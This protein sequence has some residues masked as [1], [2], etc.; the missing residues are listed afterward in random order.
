MTEERYL[1]AARKYRPQR[2][3]ELVAQEHVAET[4]RNAIRMDRL[5]HV[6]LFSGPRGVGK[7]TTA[8]ILAKAINCTGRGDDPEPCRKCNS[9]KD[10]ESQRSL[11]IFEIDAASNNKVD[12]VRDLRETVHIPPQG[13][14]RKIYIIDEV[15]MLS[16][17]AFNALLKTLEEPPSYALFIFA[18]TEPH[19]VLPTIL[20]RCQRFDFRR[21]P[22]PAILQHLKQI[23]TEEGITADEES[24][25]LIARKGDGALRDAL[26][27][28]DQ[29][30]ALCGTSLV[31][32]EL[33][34]ALRVVDVDYFFEIVEFIARHE[35]SAIL[36]F[37][38]R[39]LSQGFDIREFLGG[40]AEHLRKLLVAVTVGA[41]LLQDVS[42]AVRARY[43]SQ[44]TLLTQAQLLRMLM[45][46]DDAL[47]ALPMATS[48]RLKFELALLKMSSLSHG[49]DLT[50][51]LTRLRNLE[52][53][54]KKGGL[55]Q[56]PSGTAGLPPRPQPTPAA[57]RKAPP[58]GQ[59]SVGAGGAKQETA[60]GPEAARYPAPSTLHVPEK[61][62]PPHL[63][64]VEP[65]GAKQE[66]VSEPQA[67]R[68]PATPTL[69]VPEKPPPPSQPDVGPESAKPEPAREPQAARSPAT[70]TLRVPEKPPPP[71]QPDVGPGSAMP[72]PARDP[73]TPSAPA[74]M[75]K[76]AEDRVGS[77]QRTA[78]QVDK[79]A[80]TTS[81]PTEAA[82]VPVQMNPEEV[83][84]QVTRRVAESHP[85][86]A[87]T[88]K[89]AQGAIWRND[90]LHVR[91]AGKSHYELIEG[92]NIEITAAIRAITQ[93][94]GLTLSL[95][96]LPAKSKQQQADEHLDQL[97]QAS[98]TVQ[99]MMDLFDVEI[100]T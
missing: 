29:A 11:N 86:T 19:K 20:S 65:G 8:R 97:R 43:S 89:G 39:V 79:A 41:P 78:E 36:L 85:S 64:G 22:V 81:A 46:A 44:S 52:D 10:L 82:A 68:S 51:A 42:E 75:E 23:C 47:M 100:V 25:L 45:I 34:A 18:T 5:A 71:S 74:A 55:R 37:S 12:D 7:T 87:D 35:T 62:S 28:F 99:V 32:S 14:I 49:L 61:T 33:A 98:P 15:H 93:N 58:H 95:E 30:V 31:Y 77:E 17:A 73:T 72:E 50:E 3:G 63:G 56:M 27:A 6:Y 16:N 21:I 84:T 57:T 26:S 48:P 53:L 66:P 96:M 60:R 92:R 91:I 94:P 2:F 59:I 38:D 90:T 83:W 88:M 24:L 76:A 40:L 54:L 4:L 80:K 1:V 9:C 13:A 69:R 70:P 67:A